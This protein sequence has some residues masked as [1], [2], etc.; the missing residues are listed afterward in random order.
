MCVTYVSAGSIQAG[1]CNVVLSSISPVDTVI[2]KVQR[3][4]IGPGDLI[5]HNDTSVGAIHPDPPYVGVVT[6][7]RPV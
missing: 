5:L 3:Q 2:N 1:K 4:T 6:P 7:V